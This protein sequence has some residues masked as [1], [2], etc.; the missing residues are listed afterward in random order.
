MKR[1]SLSRFVILLTLLLAA[2]GLHNGCG[3]IADK[4]RLPVAVYDDKVITRGD[5]SKM[6]REMSDKERPQIRSKVDLRRVLFQ[7]I[8]RKITIPLGQQLA[9][10][11]KIAVPLDLA[12]EQYF[13]ASGDDEQMYRMLW[14]LKDDSQITGLMKEYKFTPQRVKSMKGLIEEGAKDKQMLM[15]AEQA[16][17]YLAAEAYQKGELK[18]S[19][20]MLQTEYEL[21]RPELDKL[22]HLHFVGIRIPASTD[23]VLA[24]AA[25]IRAEIDSGTGFETVA[26][27]IQAQEPNLIFES[28]IENNPTL[29]RFKGFWESASGANPGDVIGPVYLPAFQ[30][31]AKGADGKPAPVT[32]P[33]TWVIFKVLEHEAARKPTIEEAKPTLIPRLISGLMTGKLREEHHVE[34]FDNNLP[35]PEL[36]GNRIGDPLLDKKK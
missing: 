22:E 27:R 25:Q 17:Q 23:N 33:D 11:N 2:I 19:D 10:E 21:R 31:Y 24:V 35:D 13:L 16:V 5:L 20:E 7:H 9:S 34:I 29:D 4:D 36:G 28:D 14:N 12:R 18:V 6:L 15:L 3:M 26:A 1:Y 8:D 30:T 32:M